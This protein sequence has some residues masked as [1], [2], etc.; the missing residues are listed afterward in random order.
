MNTTMSYAELKRKVKG[1]NVYLSILYYYG[2][3]GNR[4]PQQ[5]RGKLKIMA[6]RSYGFDIELLNKPGQTSRLGIERSSLCSIENNTLTIY[7][8][9]YRPLNADEQ[10]AL[11]HWHQIAST[12]AYQEQD[13]IDAVSDGSV[14][15]WKKV[16]F[17]RNVGGKDMSYLRSTVADEMHGCR[18]AYDPNDKS[19]LVIR[20]KNVRGEPIMRYKLSFGTD[21]GTRAYEG[22]SG[23]AY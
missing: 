1:G 10:E 12:P 20:D 8:P 22:T 13:R 9:G 16:A 15:W 3:E 17:F 11:N 4:I 21:T 6:A 23:Y 19:K 7:E 5:L 14:N 18:L 2:K